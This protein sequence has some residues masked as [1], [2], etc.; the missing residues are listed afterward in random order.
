MYN[1]INSSIFNTRRDTRR[2]FCIANNVPCITPQTQEVLEHYLLAYKPKYCLEIWCALWISLLTTAQIIW[3]W[4]WILQWVE[5]SEPNVKEIQ[6]SIQQLEMNNVI[7]HHLNATHV[8]RECII[9]HKLDRVFL[10]WAKGQYGDYLST[11]LPYMAENWIIILDDVIMY[12]N[13]LKSL[14][15]TLEKMQIRYEIFKLWDGDWIMLIEMKNQTIK[16]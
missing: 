14:Y 6:N 16:W 7:I 4:G 15:A 12:D 8:G 9:T 3:W 10:D 5:W 11:I 2:E 13:K 1:K